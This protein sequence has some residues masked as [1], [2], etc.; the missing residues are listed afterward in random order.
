[1]MQEKLSKSVVSPENLQYEKKVLFEDE[2]LEVEK[3]SLDE[4]NKQLERLY[5]CGYMYLKE[6]LT[7][8]NSSTEAKCI[9]DY[10]EK[11]NEEI[12]KNPESIKKIV[13]NE[14]FEKGNLE[15]LVKKR[16][17]YIAI[18]L[19]EDNIE[20]KAENIVNL[21]IP[22]FSKEY[23]ENK[24]EE[25]VSA[26]AIKDNLQ[27][28]VDVLT[29]GNDILKMF[30]SLIG[31]KKFILDYRAEVK[32]KGKK[33]RCPVCGSEDRFAYISED[34]ILSDAQK[35]IEDHNTL[36]KEKAESLKEK[37]E[38][39]SALQK[40]ILLKGIEAVESKIKTLDELILE[41]EQYNKKCQ[42]YTEIITELHKIN[43]ERYSFSSLNTKEKTEDAIQKNKVQI[44][45]ENELLDIIS[46]MKEI[47]EIIGFS[48][49]EPFTNNTIREVTNRI[50]DEL[51]LKEF[52]VGLLSKKVDAIKNY[53][54]NDEVLELKK[55][56]DNTIETVRKISK[57][58]AELNNQKELAN[59]KMQEIKEVKQKLEMAE[60]ENIGPFL[61]K[62]FHKLSKDIHIKEILLEKRSGEKNEKELELCDENKH[63]IMNMLSDGQ[64]SVFMLSYFLGNA[65]RLSNTEEMSIYLMDDITSCLDDINMLS[66]LDLLKYQLKN[67][68]GVFGQIFFASCNSRIQA[69]ME[70]KAQAC[71]ISCRKI[72]T[73]DYSLE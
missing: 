30:T 38:K 54:K 50:N 55:K 25:L 24:K 18:K 64:L 7:K 10:L 70:W 20:E 17:E 59:N 51:V 14:Y 72:K 66:F 22:S 32:E 29:K 57:K 16:T 4:L 5:C 58:I 13:E 71:G 40:E 31:N 44:M 1:M 2:N 37:I 8:V 68:S 36:L 26:K 47:S 41:Y 56:L 6:K 69:L 73:N 63:P 34:E 35:Y 12:I 49:S 21:G 27:K 61:T 65:F 48:L 60:Y 53:K 46:Q 39:I 15:K 19:T 43:F 11:V 67:D 42:N 33:I 23:W 45:P 62:I 3:M 52:S 28:E 9:G